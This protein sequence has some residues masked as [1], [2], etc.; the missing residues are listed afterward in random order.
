MVQRGLAHLTYDP[1]TTTFRYVNETRTRRRSSLEEDVSGTKFCHLGLIWLTTAPSVFQRLMVFVL[2]V[3]TYATCLFYLD[4][5][6]VFA[7]LGPGR[8]MTIS[9]HT[10]SVHVFRQI[11]NLDHFGTMPHHYTKSRL[12]AR[13]SKPWE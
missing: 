6:I 5:T 2:C 12:F 4:D 13:Y 7:R 1:A 8:Y 3:L 10:T 11:R 9:V